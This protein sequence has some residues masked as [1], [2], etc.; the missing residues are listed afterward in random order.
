M[1]AL[2]ACAKQAPPGQQ[3]GSAATSAAPA[4]ER[5]QASPFQRTMTPEKRA[6]CEASGGTVERRGMV[7]AETCVHAYADGGKIC[8]DS[9]QC[10]GKCVGSPGA[11]DQRA[12]G[13]CQKDDKLFGCYAEIV[14]GRPA[15]AICVD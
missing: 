1:L 7:G 2:A 14:G 13:S 9:A 12:A 8:T 11:A 6:A 4:T 15:Y 10:E 3:G 5:G